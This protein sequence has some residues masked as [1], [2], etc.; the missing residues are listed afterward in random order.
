MTY[1]SRLSIIFQSQKQ[2]I[3]TLK[4]KRFIQVSS[5]IKTSAESKIVTIN[6]PHP[7]TFCVR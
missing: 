1:A 7:I 5:R 3:Y 2:Y 6:I 4:M